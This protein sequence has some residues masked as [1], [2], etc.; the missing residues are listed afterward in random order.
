MAAQDQVMSKN[1]FENNVLKEETDSK[2]C[3]RNEHEE[4]IDY[5]NCNKGFKGK[6]ESIQCLHYKRQLHLQ[7]KM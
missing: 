5:L 3:W 1:Y 7:L 6:S 2:F 4:I